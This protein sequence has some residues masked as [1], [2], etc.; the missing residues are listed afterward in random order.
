[1]ASQILTRGQLEKMSSE[2]LIASFLALQ[3]N[4]IL[5]QNHLFQQNRDISKKLLEITSKIDSL[6]K[7][8]EEL[9]SHV[10]VAQNA[11]KILQEV[12]K[13][14]SSKLV[15][16]E[17]QHHK[18]EQYTR[19]ECLDFSGIPNTVA[20]KD[21]ENVILHLLQEIGINL[22]KSRIVACHKLGKTDR[23]TVKFLNRKD[24]EN[25]HSNKKKLED[26]DVSYL[27][28]N[29]DMQGRNDMTTGSQND[30]REGCLSRKGK[31]L[32]HRISARTTDIC[33]V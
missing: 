31:M 6:A 22:D 1:M 14:K 17:R 7:E 33:M 16:L 9:T 4:I 32:Y 26:V 27:L 12:F 30:R 15:E 2:N 20:P 29:N 13:T 21:L 28:S 19:R 25:L 5:Q 3:D 8:N 24:A 11:P 23:T 10:S 18:L